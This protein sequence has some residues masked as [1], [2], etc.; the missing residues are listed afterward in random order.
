MLAI[1]AFGVQALA[2]TLAAK[3]L[4]GA[5]AH[6]LALA[7]EVGLDFFGGHEGGSMFASFA[8]AAFALGKLA[9]FAS[10]FVGKP[11][12]L[13]FVVGVGPIKGLTSLLLWYLG[14]L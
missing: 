4:V 12:P 10:W 3:A 14:K 2:F 7:F 1:G 8:L 5:F 9:D 13:C 11:S 6:R